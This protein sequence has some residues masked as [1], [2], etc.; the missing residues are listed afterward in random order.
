[1]MLQGAM[2]AAFIYTLGFLAFFIAPIMIVLHLAGILIP[3]FYFNK[4]AMSNPTVYQKRQERFTSRRKLALR[5]LIGVLLLSG[6][7]YSSYSLGMAPFTRSNAEKQLVEETAE[8]YLEQK[9]DEPFK[10]ADISYSW[11]AGSYSLR[12]FP[13]QDPH[14]KFILSSDTSDPPVIS[15]ENYL[16]KLWG[17]QL[18]DKLSPV[19]KEL[20]PNQAFIGAGVYTS[21]SDT[22]ERDYEQLGLSINNQYVTMIV[23]VDLSDGLMTEKQRVFELIQHMPNYM[24]PGETDLQIDYYPASMNTNK[25]V[26]KI[27]EDFDTFNEPDR[28]SHTLWV[29]DISKVTSVDDIEIIEVE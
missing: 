6:I 10:I 19:I 9:Y 8:S 16:N 3:I 12:A 17:R 21:S 26:N 29:F 5:T 24:L 1:M 15:G 13:E 7:V 18:E 23:F 11:G 14:L 2:L 25:N 28:K 22:M 27:Q 20:Y 4:R